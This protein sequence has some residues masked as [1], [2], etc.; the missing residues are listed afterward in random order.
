MRPSLQTVVQAVLIALLAGSIPAAIT[1]WADT[2]AVKAE[3]TAARQELKD[4]Q[5][6]VDQLRRAVVILDARTRALHP[7]RT[8]LPL[9]P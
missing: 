8:F 9:N 1:L 2:R 6:A 5:K 4:S 7:E 3:L